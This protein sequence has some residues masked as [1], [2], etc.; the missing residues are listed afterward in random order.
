M[1]VWYSIR[2]RCNVHV[3]SPGTWEKRRNTWV[4]IERVL[5]WYVDQTGASSA[6]FCSYSV[7]RIH[8]LCNIQSLNSV[9][10][11]CCNLF[12]TV[13]CVHG[14]H[15]STNFSYCCAWVLIPCTGNSNY[16]IRSQKTMQQ[17]NIIISNHR[18][19]NI[20]TTLLS[21]K[22]SGIKNKRVH[23]MKLQVTIRQL[24]EV[25]P[26]SQLEKW[27]STFLLFFQKLC[28]MRI[29]AYSALCHTIWMIYTPY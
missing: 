4:Q 16:N 23:N 8:N 6:W 29:M 18:A 13:S 19:D 28:F 2:I 15:L 26:H 10:A 14:E 21:C 3:L 25:L 11:I 9:L 5:F 1:C 24:S 20:T 7:V 22:I 17:Y 12:A 27:Q